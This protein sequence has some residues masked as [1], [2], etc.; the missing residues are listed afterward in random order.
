M[1][2]QID[3][4][5]KQ[6][7]PKTL[8]QDFSLV[9]EPKEKLAII[10]RNGA[11]KTTLFNILSGLN[12]DFKGQI[13]QG[14]GLQVVATRQEFDNTPGQSCLDY[15]ISNLPEY[16][17][18]KHVIDT[19][20]DSMQHNMDLIAK[21]S[22]AVQ[23]FSDLN[24]Y[25]I[26]PHI[27][28]ALAAYQIDETL[29]LGDFHSLSGGQKRLVE[30]VRVEL[31]GSTLAL[32]D[33]P[34]NHMDYVAK[35]AF[36]DWLEKVDHAVVVI[37]HDRDVL[38]V[39][40]RVVELKDKKA[41]SFPGNYNNYLKQNSVSSITAVNQ[42]EIAQRSL[43]KLKQQLLFAKARKAASPA[44]KV[45]E[46]RLQREYDALESALS[47][48]SLWIDKESVGD[49][50][51]ASAVN[52]DRYKDRNVR[53]SKS[54]S[55]G[56]VAGL[57][58]VKNL[59][60]GYN[61]PLFTG[62]SFTLSSGDRLHLMGRNGVGKS[63]LVKAIIASAQNQ[64]P[65]A[66][67]IAGTIEVSAKVKLGIYEQEISSSW[68]SLKLGEA[69]QAA[70]K[71][72]NVP[73]ND[74][75]IKQ[76]MAD[77]LFDPGADFDHPVGQLSGGQKARLQII[78]LLAGHPNLLILDEPTNHLD[79]PSIEEFE[80]ALENYHGAVIY[81]SHDSYFAEAMGGDV[82]EIGSK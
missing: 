31:S 28:N 2:L 72:K 9:I 15:V 26:E 5:S 47:K 63:T 33:E 42:Y 14:R 8:L 40:D 7:G 58:E 32:I 20:P 77:Y 45:M 82:L 34:T 53:L 46:T 54:A 52:Y 13:G 73:V 55:S 68:L 74:Q 10:G 36:I 23:R 19:Y 35:A 44:Y 24:Y 6:I 38:K 64:P 62:I 75:L 81:V 76:T 57:V 30:L 21:Y 80:R 67:I 49:L 41:Y 3:I 18:L 29:A 12:T 25:D 22:D 65:Q 71:A 4:E 79:L 48:P 69:I 37:T 61:K 50:K 59:S 56:H 43:Q 1:L 11:G 39:V 16:A 78:N 66:Q 51:G 60:L 70:Y 17:E 27:L